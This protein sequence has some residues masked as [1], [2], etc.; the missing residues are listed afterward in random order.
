MSIQGDIKNL[1]S[2]K[3]RTRALFPTTKI[4]AISDDNG[5]GLNAFLDSMVHVGDIIYDAET[6][7]VNADTLG[8]RTVNEFAL[9][10]NVNAVFDNLQTQIDGKA[11]IGEYATQDFV[12]SKIAEAQLDFEGN[13]DLSGYATKDDVANIVHPVKSING[14]TGAVTLT[15]SDIEAAPSSHTHDYAPSSHTHNYAGSSSA[16]GAATSANKLNTNA[17]GT[18]QPVYFANGVPVATT[19]TLGANVPSGAKFTDTVYT[20][21]SHTAKSS[22]LYKITVDG[23]GHVSAATAVAKAD[24]TALGIPST[25]TTYSSATTS[26]A[27]LMSAADKTKLNGIASGANAYTHPSYTAKNS[28]LY[29]ITVDSSGHVSAATAVTKADIT[30]LGI[31]A[32]DTNTTYTLGSFGITASATELN[33]TDGV[34]SNIQT[35]LNGKAASSH[36]HDDRYFTESEINT[37]LSSKADATATGLRTMLANGATVLSSHQYGTSL[38][39]AGTAGRIFF[40]KVT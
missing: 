9:L 1:Y 16:G 25:N 40:K 32:Q 26:A 13:I 8:G 5:T 20:H 36:T 37:K 2:D 19:Y 30:A 33:Y 35:Q 29:K 21:P 3:E 14:K 27:G 10:N 4:N 12:T 38:P 15:A 11:A 34:T 31:P 17:G 7:P 23:N 39:S 18:T 28:G 6:A 22:G 24:I